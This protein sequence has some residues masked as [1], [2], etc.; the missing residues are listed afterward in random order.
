MERKDLKREAR[1]SLKKNY[2]KSV[3][4]C[5]IL[6]FILGGG[7]HYITKDVL[8]APHNNIVSVTKDSIS[9]KYKSIKD[10]INDVVVRD[11]DKID[12]RFN[13]GVLSLIYNEIKA[14]GSFVFGILN[15]INLVFFQNSLSLIIVL[16]TGLI[17][18]F[19]FHV[20]VKNVL[21]VGAD[22]YFL[23]NRKYVDTGIDKLF[24][25]Y[26]VKRTLKVA[27]AMLLRDLYNF[28]WMFTIVGG[29]VK[30]Y[31]YLLVPYILAENP[32]ISAKEAIKLSQMM[33]KGRKWFAFKLDLSFVGWYVLGICTFNVVNI[34]Y[35]FP[36]YN[37]VL[38][39]FYMDVRRFYLK[40]KLSC[41]E[42]LND[43]YLEGSGNDLSYP[44]DKF[45]IPEVTHRKWLRFD[46]KRDYT[47][48][49]YILFFFAFSMIGWIWE[50]VFCFFDNGILVNRGTMFGPWLPIYG[51]GGL[52]ILI[53]LKRFRDKPLLLFITS[54]I[55]C[56][57]VEYSTAW[58]LETFNHMKWWDYS[59]YFLNI[60]GR[61]CL[62]GLL[63]FGLGGCCFTYFAAPMIQN[64]FRK[65]KDKTLN[66]VCII[67][68]SLYLI[69]SIYSHFYPN[70]GEGITY[71]GCYEV[72]DIIKQ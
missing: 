7:Y 16:I 51:S 29:I 39:E 20:F 5:F 18:Y 50:V 1:V 4:I 59:G 38:A 34:F 47:V 23:E 42:L 2:F 56:G 64:F 37:A 13:S 32:D 72:V 70:H 46:Y 25:P 67:L 26:R 58:Y 41:Y 60:H 57:I 69:D 22:R 40:N 21:I 30:H 33:M 10:V 12:S 48:R 28:L 52:L 68:I 24:F 8:V 17:L 11:E 31:S 61:V 45:S 49:D 35:V 53:L 63:V 27:Y 19:L 3:F 71:S 9:F 65:F 36:Y 44:K 43:L 6:V 15:V 14:A 62:E 54:F 66:I 55:L